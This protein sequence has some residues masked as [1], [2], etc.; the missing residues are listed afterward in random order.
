MRDGNGGRPRA[1]ASA[2]ES[3]GK[4]HALKMAL[5]AT[6]KGTYLRHKQQ[7]RAS[8]HPSSF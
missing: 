2:Y 6:L 5:T 4:P 3:G 8:F 1:Q 7:V